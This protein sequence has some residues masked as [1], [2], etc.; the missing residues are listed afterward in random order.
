MSKTVTVD[1]PREDAEG[2]ECEGVV[3]VTL[4]WEP[5]DRNYGA[6]ADGRR[7]VFVSG[8]WESEAAESCSRGHALTLGER[9]SVGILAADETDHEDEY[10]GPDGPDDDY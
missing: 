8:Y 10:Y 2:D 7:G 3:N 4:E 9:E 6:D 1:C 5:G